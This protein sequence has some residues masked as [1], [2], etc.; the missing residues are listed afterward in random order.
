LSAV[1]HRRFSQGRQ[2]TVTT[3]TEPGLPNLFKLCRA[4]RLR[5]RH[6]PGWAHRRTGPSPG[7]SGGSRPGTG[8]VSAAGPGQG[9]PRSRCQAGEVH[10]T[11][12]QIHTVTAT[13]LASSHLFLSSSKHRGATSHL[14]IHGTRRRK[15]QNVLSFRKHLPFASG[16]YWPRPGPA[17]T[18]GPG[19]PARA[20]GPSNFNL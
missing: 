4:A 13:S 17:A 20:L 10:A 14:M 2:E 5:V 1:W 18:A 3:G 8:G 19:V 11:Q 12:Q 7:R 15:V 16:S 9:R 6:V